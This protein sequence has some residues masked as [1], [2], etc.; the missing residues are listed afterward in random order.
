MKKGQDSSFLGV[1]KADNRI[2]KFP[3][4]VRDAKKRNYSDLRYWTAKDLWIQCRIRYWI[5]LRKCIDR[6]FIIIIDFEYKQSFT[7]RVFL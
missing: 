2:K 1:G 6:S 7:G 4:N 5:K 3:Q